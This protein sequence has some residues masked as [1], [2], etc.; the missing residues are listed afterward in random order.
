MRYYLTLNSIDNI[1]HKSDDLSEV[2]HQLVLAETTLQAE[3]YTCGDVL[4][5]LTLDAG[6][7]EYNV[8]FTIVRGYT[9]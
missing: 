1:I 3:P 5:I 8:L 4:Q 6:K 9:P 2:F 7:E